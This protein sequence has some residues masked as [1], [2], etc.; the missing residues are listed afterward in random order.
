MDYAVDHGIRLFDTA[1]AYGAAQAQTY[2]RE[3]F[4]LVD[5]R[6]VSDES[7]SS[8]KIIGRWLQARGG[9]RAITL[10][11]KINSNYTVPHIQTA[12]TDS[13]ERLQTDKI[14]IYLYHACDPR[15]EIAEAVTAADLVVKRGWTTVVGCSNF[16]ADQ[17]QAHL[18]C[19]RRIGV[20][21]FEVIES[22][23]NLVARDIEND[24]L[25]LA[26]QEQLGVLG[27]SPLAGGFLTGKYHPDRSTIPQGTRF[28][29]IPGYADLYF[30]RE[31]FAQVNALRALAERLHLPMTQLAM[32]WT[33]RQPDVTTMLVGARTPA[34]LDNA[35]ATERLALDDDVFATMNAW[36]QS[37]VA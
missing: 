18:E 25:P 14:D 34:Q 13:L 37:T 9:R 22:A 28:D 30:K 23:Y 33:L 15:I 2:R 8:E 27:Y 29:V 3:R 4:G 5:R 31:A 19:S 17:L 36:S 20:S 24:I 21:R 35:L 11:T 32:A 10:L 7:H 26:R 1:E 16:S 12:I 6:E